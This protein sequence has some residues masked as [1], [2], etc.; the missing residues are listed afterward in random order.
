M[1]NAPHVNFFLGLIR[2]WESDGHTI[3][4]TTRPLSKTPELLAK[5]G[6]GYK[7]VGRHYGKNSFLKIIGFP[8]RCFQLW[9][10]LRSLRIDRACSQSS[11]YSPIVS[12]LLGV[13]CL[14]TNDN[15][16]ALGNFFAFLFSDKVVLPSAL[17]DWV[18]NKPVLGQKLFYPGVKEGIY[19]HGK[20]RPKRKGPKGD[21]KLIYFRPEPWSAQYHT[22][23]GCEFIDL[24]DQL[25]IDFRVKL[26]PRSKEQS[27]FFGQLIKRGLVIEESIKSLEEII[28]ECDV[29]IGAGGSMSREACL[30]GVPTISLYRGKILAVDHVL[31][32]AGL[33]YHFDTIDSD[34]IRELLSSLDVRKRKPELLA[35]GKEAF[36]LIAKSTLS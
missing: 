32:K 25:L 27:L 15:E 21:K 33:L 7:V 30:L 29:F 17:S 1:C 18:K 8:I 34:A 20:F 14:Y 31:L 22:K 28:A 36:D 19:L 9:F 4:I 5:T 26:I 11:F 12:R 10:Y 24:L 3:V 16:F 13:K 35:R 6:L 2:F 23:A